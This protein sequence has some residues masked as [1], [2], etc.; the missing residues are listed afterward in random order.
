M[1]TWWYHFLQALH[2]T[3]IRSFPVLV[4]PPCQHFQVGTHADPVDGCHPPIVPGTGEPS[5]VEDEGKG[6]Q[7]GQG[8]CSGLVLQG[9]SR[10]PSLI[11]EE[12]PP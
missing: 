3:H 1:Q 7:S 8:G 6:A 4:V 10:S 5:P 2:F 11:S 9:L 12:E